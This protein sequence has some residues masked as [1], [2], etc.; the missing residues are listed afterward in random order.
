[1]VARRRRVR[2]SLARLRRASGPVLVTLAE[3]AGLL[4]L[5]YGCW[6]A[7]HPLGFVVGGLVLVW[8]MQGVGNDT[9]SPRG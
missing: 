9:D 5:A 3:I 2:N 7:W 4:A 1:V 8:L 6:L